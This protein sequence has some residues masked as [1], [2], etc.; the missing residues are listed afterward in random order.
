MHLAKPHKEVG[1]FENLR[2][3]SI[4]S[5][6]YRLYSGIR[7][8][9]VSMWLTRRVPTC[10]HGGIK[11]RGTHTALTVSLCEMQKTQRNMRQANGQRVLRRSPGFKFLGASDLSKAFDK[12]AGTL[13]GASLSRMGLPQGL[14][15]ALEQAW[16]QQKRF[17]VLGSF[18]GA[19]CLG[20]IGCLPQGDPSSP[21]AL[22]GPIAEAQFRLQQ[23][24][25][26]SGTEVRWGIFIDDR[27]WLTKSLDTCL[28]IGQ[29]WALEVRN[30]G[31][32]ENRSKSDY[33][34]IGTK[35][36]RQHMQQEINSRNMPGTVHIRPKVLGTSIQT[37][38]G[39]RGTGASKEEKQRVDRTKQ[40]IQWAKSIPGEFSRRLK[41][42]RGTAMAI[43][44]TPG[45]ARLEA[46]SELAKVQTCFE[47]ASGRTAHKRRGPLRS[48]L[49]G[50]SSSARYKHGC[51]QAYWVLES[52][53]CRAVRQAW[54][55]HGNTQGPV[56]LLRTWLK[57]QGWT[58]ARMWIWNHKHC[59]LSLVPHDCRVPPQGRRVVR[60]GG[61]GSKKLLQH[62]M[63]EAWRATQ[64]ARWL[65]GTP[66]RSAGIPHTWELVSPRYKGISKIIDL[67]AQQR[68]QV[69]GHAH[70]AAH[71][72][73]VATGH[74]VSPAAFQVMTGAQ[75]SS[76]E[77]CH[78]GPRTFDH[79]MWYC[80]R[81]ADTRVEPHDQLQKQ[82]GWPTTER[83]REYNRRVVVHMASVR[84]K[85]LE[86]RHGE[87]ETLPSGGRDFS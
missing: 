72:F 66:N 61:G 8:Q 54:H 5:C 25:D 24:F 85:W 22:L 48:L 2:P 81:F 27:H 44:S 9:H 59:N 37:H 63:R 62:T 73:A 10:F 50:H 15:R 87:G 65:Q 34:V 14:V 4:G 18:V 52:S 75:V 71:A 3:I 26:P 20:N 84:R 39:A 46:L 47:E 29:R 56:Q 60:F 30:M 69:T 7:M 51:W 79:D 13:A 28:S 32:D 41:F 21:I 49:E 77:F 16:T 70:L 83:N 45:F 1:K 35:K 11:G 86:E 67:L 57:R 82:L 17:M 40:L 64:W 55:R 80:P 31:M 58:E 12:M 43:I 36:A 78:Q 23:E 33:C 19:K 38:R 74:A 42:L 68:S 53:D 6:I 76:C